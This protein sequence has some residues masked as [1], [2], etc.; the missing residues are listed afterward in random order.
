MDVRPVTVAVG[1]FEDLLMRGLRGLVEDDPGLELVSCGA[2]PEELARVLRSRA[3][4][5]AIVDH[6]SLH[7]PSEVRSLCGEHRATSF[8]LFAEGLSEA[9]C[10]Q[11]LAF[12]AS[13]CLSR[14]TQAR[15][16]LNAIHL[17]ARGMR[18]T[19]REFHRPPGASGALTEREAE[20]LVELQRRRGNAQIAA[21]LHISI[22][23]VRTHARNIYRKLGVSSR[24]EL[25]GASV[26]DTARAEG[27]AEQEDSDG[28]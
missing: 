18:L 3:P 25:L 5:V 4:Q 12:G 10:G 20:I 6:A 1:R 15:D 26:R 28:G 8:V 14:A 19:P 22:E 17:A 24:R 7:S 23:T 13:A 21:D 9:E 16:V 11:M 2:A 27:S